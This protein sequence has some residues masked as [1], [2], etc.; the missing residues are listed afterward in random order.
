MKRVLV[1]AL[2]AA[3]CGLA[4]IAQADQPPPSGV[5]SLTATASI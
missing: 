1:N 5:V 4:A 3:A 2:V